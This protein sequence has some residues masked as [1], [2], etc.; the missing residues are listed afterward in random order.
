[1]RSQTTDLGP[2]TKSVTVAA[3]V[4]RAFELYTNGI[5]TWWPLSTFSASQRAVTCVFESGEGGRIFERTADGQ[6][7]PWGIVS[8]WEP[9]TRVVHTWH[10]GRPESTAQEVEM[11]FRSEGD[12]TRVEVEHRGWER[13]GEGA[14]AAVRSYA[15]GWE[16]VLGECYAAAANRSA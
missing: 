12:G 11:R 13:Y 3:P 14:E 10:P 5:G 15:G 2:V 4:E 16:F 6:E 7:F 8:V 9:P 1:M